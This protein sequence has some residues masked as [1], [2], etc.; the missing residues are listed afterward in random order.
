MQLERAQAI[1][2]KTKGFKR[3]TFIAKLFT[4]HIVYSEVLGV[5]PIVEAAEKGKQEQDIEYRNVS[6]IAGKVISSVNKGVTNSI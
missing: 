3:P 2:K 5:K 1:L 6:N 4:P